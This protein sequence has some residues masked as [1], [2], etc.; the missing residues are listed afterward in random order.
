MKSTELTSGWTLTA[1]GGDP[2]GRLPDEIAAAVPGTSHVDLLA[3]GLIPDPYLDGN[4]FELRWLFD[5]DWQYRTTLDPTRLDL[6][7]TDAGERVDVV[8]EGVDTMATIA[9]GAPGSTSTELGRTANMHRTYRFDVSQLLTG[10]P[11][12]LSVDLASATT[13]AEAE[14]ARLGDRPAPYPTPFNYLR[15]MACSFGWDWGP[16]LR[17]AGLWKPVRLERW[18]TARLASVRPLVTVDPDGT[19]RVELHVELERAAE[20]PLTLGAEIGPS[21]A[22]IGLEPDEASAV[23]TVEVP[24]ARLWWPAGYGEHPLYDLTLTLAATP[25]EELDRWQRRIGFRTVELDTGADEF[26]SAFRFSI[27]GAPVFV[28]GA[29]WIPDDHFLTRITAGSAGPPAGSGGRGEP[30]PDAGLGRRDLRDRRRSTRPATSAGCWS[31]RTSCSPA[32][33]IRR[34]SRWPPRSRPRRARTSSG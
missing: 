27:N 6:S 5:V 28:K 17:T 30:E 1:T 16:D 11:L 15:K 7:A 19:G 33:P 34:S 18:R 24:D 13:Y 32:P 22:M 26:G 14:K 9:M 20:G 21:S 2:E 10:E 31:G 29:N 4:E 12:E 23:L 3:A 25:D 8:F